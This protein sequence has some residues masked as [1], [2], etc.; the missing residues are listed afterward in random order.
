MVGD[1]FVY[2]T[3]A[4]PVDVYKGEVVILVPLKPLVG[5]LDCSIGGKVVLHRE[6]ARIG[7]KGK[8]R[9]RF[10]QRVHD[11][12]HKESQPSMDG[13]FRAQNLLECHDSM[14]AKSSDLGKVRAWR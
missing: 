12:V 6:I 2:H 13:T 5:H 8:R 7:N 3:K 14:F 11:R 4:R 1:V 10:N 9:S